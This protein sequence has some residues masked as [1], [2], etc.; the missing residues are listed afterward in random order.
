MPQ[1][2]GG[3]LAPDANPAQ[4]APKVMEPAIDDQQSVETGESVQTA[5]DTVAL[6]PEAVQSD[7]NPANP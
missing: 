2:D 5:D 3:A 1:T 4:D 7:E 6:D